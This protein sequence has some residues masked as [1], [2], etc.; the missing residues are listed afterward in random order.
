MVVRDERGDLG[1]EV[2]DSAAGRCLELLEV[3]SCGV[4]HLP[5][6]A[7]AGSAVV[8]DDQ[9]ESLERLEFP[10][11]GPLAW[12]VSGISRQVYPPGI[13]VATPLGDDRQEPELTLRKR[14]VTHGASPGWKRSASEIP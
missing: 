1:Y 10:Q 12:A 5:P 2:V 6:A 14:S 11:D 7:D 3:R 8:S 13:P 9:P 4:G